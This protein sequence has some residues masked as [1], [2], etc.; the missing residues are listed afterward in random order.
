M[1]E[2]GVGWIQIR[3]GLRLRGRVYPDTVVKHPHSQLDKSGKLDQLDQP[4]L[5]TNSNH[6]QIVLEDTRTCG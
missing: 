6:C 3:V 4:T 2:C 1:F 5:P